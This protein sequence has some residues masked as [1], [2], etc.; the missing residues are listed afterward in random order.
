MKV[1]EE[2]LKLN[3]WHSGYGS[4]DSAL[5]HYARK[6]RSEKTRENFCVAVM[7]FCKYCALDPDAVVPLTPEEASKHCQAFTDSLRDKGYSIR[8]VN[9][10]QAYLSTFFR[11]NGFTAGRSLKVERYH[12]PARYRKKP[13]YVPTSDAIY[14]MGF[15]AGSPKNRAMVFALYTSGLRNS[16]L[17][18]VRYGDVG[19]ELELGQNFVK[20]SV[21]P[22]MK[23]VDPAA[24]K[25]NMPY[26]TFV[27]PEAVKAMRDYIEERSHRQGSILDEEPLFC[28]D[29]NH[30]SN[31]KQRS[32]PV[33]KKGL[34]D[35]VTR[36]ARQAGIAHWSDVT[37]NCLRKAFESVLR[38]NGLDPKDQEFLMGHILPGV[39]D[40][41]YDSTKVE[42]LRT[43]YAKLGFFKAAQVDKLE[44]IKAF[45]QTLGINEIEIKIQKLREK[46]N[47]LGE[48]EALGRIMRQ[49]LGTRSMENKKI[50]KRKQEEDSNNHSKYQSRIANEKELVPLIDD[51]WEIVKE[52][53]NGK[54]VV[55]RELT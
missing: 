14:K 24:C 9:V 23:K 36:A 29:S 31:E 33:S 8:Y 55:R 17:R 38:N 15:A 13:E 22:E 4:V 11:E 48:M 43:K 5:R 28:S 1:W 46:Q 35:M 30:V 49:E 45:A 18:A 54:L 39:Q 25:G 27:G 26:Y 32:I 44:M 19:K 10:N 12:Q 20:I 16:T 42:E 40:P 6:I 37:P 41:Y 34:E 50:K 2:F 52:L 51:G 53:K 3:G 7:L 47:D 21:Y